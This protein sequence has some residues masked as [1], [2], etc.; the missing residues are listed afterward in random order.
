MTESERKRFVG[1]AVKDRERYE[2]ECKAY[3][4]SDVPKPPL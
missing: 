2:I 1:L 4:Q 3:R